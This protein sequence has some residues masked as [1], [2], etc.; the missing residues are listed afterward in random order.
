[1]RGILRGVILF[2]ILGSLIWRSPAT[3][4]AAAGVPGIKMTSG[5]FVNGEMLPL[6]CGLNYGNV[7]PAFAWTGAP[8]GTKSFALICDDPDAPAGDWVHWVIYNLPA[9]QT[10]LPEHVPAKEVLPNGARQGV[11]SFGRIGYD[12]P[13]PPSGVHRYFFRLYA[14]NIRIDLEKATKDKL[15]EAMR[16]HVLAVGQMMGKYAK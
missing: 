13:S 4:T 11:N 5:T 6:R 8:E 15:T 7:S 2:G 16:G 10:G 9:D 1:M 3:K 14:L 12:G